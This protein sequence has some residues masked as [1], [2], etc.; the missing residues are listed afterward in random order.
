MKKTLENGKVSDSEVSYGSNNG[1]ALWFKDSKTG[2]IK[3]E[4]QS[5]VTVLGHELIHSLGTM[6]GTSKDNVKAI[7]YFEGKSF[8]E[9]ERTDVEELAHLLWFFYIIMM[10][11]DKRGLVTQLKMVI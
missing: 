9:F 10:K 4:K 6:D 11:N 7:H 5:D 3:H 2:K 8:T 1:N